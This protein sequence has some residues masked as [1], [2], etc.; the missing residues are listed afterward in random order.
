MINLFEIR[1]FRTKRL[2]A[3]HVIPGDGPNIIVNE[4]VKS[5][6]VRWG[7]ITLFSKDKSTPEAL[8]TLNIPHLSFALSNQNIILEVF[9][10]FFF[11]IWNRPRIIFLHSFYPSLL[12]IPLRF[13]TPKTLFIPV[14]HHNMVHHL[15]NRTLAVLADKMISFFSKKI[16]A[17]SNAVK[18]TLIEEGCDSRKISVIHNGLSVN[19]NLVKRTVK[20]DNTLRLLAVGRLD[21][22]KNYEGLIQICD[23]LRNRGVNFEV[24]ILGVG[25]LEYTNH[26]KGLVK[27]LDLETNVIFHGRKENV[28]SWYQDSDIFVHTALDE[29]CPLVLIEALYSGIPIVSSNRGGCEEVLDGITKSFDTNDLSSFVDE[30]IHISN[31]LE[32]YR[33]SLHNKSLAISKKFSAQRMAESYAGLV[34]D[35]FNV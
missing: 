7:V 33:A 5:T 19:M 10:M 25:S 21:W 32:V 13:L 29:A 26:I 2:D 1:T 34:E 17:V 23:L 30:I 11:I 28:L 18:S 31:N 14:R 24:N 22:Q 4:V 27:D 9:F 3:I 20:Q 6:K 16:V 8:Q 35:A 12:A 15:Q